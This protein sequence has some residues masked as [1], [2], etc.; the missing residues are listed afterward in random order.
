MLR[1]AVVAVVLSAVLA[2]PKSRDGLS[3]ADTCDSEKCQAPNCRC[4]STDIPGGLDPSETPQV[5]SMVKDL[6]KT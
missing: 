4:F 3:L 2:A 6:N 5:N 1:L